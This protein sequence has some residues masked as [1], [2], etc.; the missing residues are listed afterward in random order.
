M[1]DTERMDDVPQLVGLDHYAIHVTDL[2]R[3]AQ[4]YRRVLGFSVLHKWNTTWMVGR[5]NI[6]VGLFLR[7][8]ATPVAPPDSKL[9]IEHVAFLVDGVKFRSL[10]E[11]ISR[12][13]VEVQ[14]PEDT[15]T[16]FSSFFRDPDGHRLEITTYHPAA[17]GTGS[18]P[19][20]QD[21]EA[22]RR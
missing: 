15:G 6:K 21:Q 16:A 14:G 2:A 7:P 17:D 10:Q 8:G 12:K 19:S 4:W 1:D 9:I 13:G 20:L 3:S 5:G 18:G 11:E 22:V